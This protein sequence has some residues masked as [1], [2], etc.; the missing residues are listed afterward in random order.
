[1][2]L[3]NFIYPFLFYRNY[4]GFYSYYFFFEEKIVLD[5]WESL[6]L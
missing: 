3:S 1:M 4:Q 5:S 6:D 2:F